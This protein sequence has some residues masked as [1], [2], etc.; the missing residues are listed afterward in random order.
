MSQMRV[1]K[2][3]NELQFQISNIIRCLADPVLKNNVISVVYVD[4][5]SDLSVARVYVSLFGHDANQEAL[6][7]FLRL[8]RSTKFIRRELSKNLNLRIVPELR[9]IRMPFLNI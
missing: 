8:R 6:D 7:P 4:T 9:F 3:N 1:Q 2:I 5:S